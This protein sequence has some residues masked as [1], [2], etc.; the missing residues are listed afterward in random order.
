MTTISLKLPDALLREVE[1]AAEA[2]RVGKSAVIRD[3]IEQGLRRRKIS[4]K[5]ITCLDMMGNWV[6]SVRGPLDLSTN[7]RYLIDAVAAHADRGRKNSR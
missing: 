5:E 2:R 7:R 3:C 4:K 6:G 1:Q